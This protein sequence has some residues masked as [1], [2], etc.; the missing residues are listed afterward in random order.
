MQPAE[1][2]FFDK[3]CWCRQR[4]LSNNL[5]YM[6]MAAERCKSPSKI[7]YHPHP[8]KN[9]NKVTLLCM[10]DQN[11]LNFFPYFFQRNSQNFSGNQFNDQK[12]LSYPPKK[13]KSNYALVLLG[14]ESKWI[15]WSSDDNL[16]IFYMLMKSLPL[17]IMMPNV[18][19]RSNN[20]CALITIR[21]DLPLFDLYMLYAILCSSSDNW[22]SANRRLEP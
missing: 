16:E 8:R 2:F 9:T 7:S 18:L 19:S 15:P 11:N 21:Y 4:L 1:K 10:A 6:V 3:C 20:V 14:V 5:R 22:S 12:S 13:R 17:Y